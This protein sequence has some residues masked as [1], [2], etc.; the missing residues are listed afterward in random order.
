MR[1]VEGTDEFAGLIS[2]ALTMAAKR[3]AVIS[4][5]AGRFSLDDVVEAYRA[6]ESGPR[7]KVLVIP[8]HNAA[9]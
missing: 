5:I 6:L 4:E 7:G 3:P 9:Q 8:S 2:Q 1:W